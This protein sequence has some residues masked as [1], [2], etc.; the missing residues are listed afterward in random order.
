MIQ[1]WRYLPNESKQRP[2]S[3]LAVS[4]TGRA[5]MA[6]P[7]LTFQDSG[8]RQGMP[9][10]LETAAYLVCTSVGGVVSANLSAS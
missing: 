4:A 9:S 8:R 1:Y 5:A 2:R 7:K 3:A 10:T 6:N